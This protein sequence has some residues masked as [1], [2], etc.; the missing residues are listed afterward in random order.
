MF[1]TDAISEFMTM[2]RSMLDD[3]KEQVRADT[4]KYLKMYEQKHEELVQ[5]R[6]NL[7]AKTKEC[8]VKASQIEAM[9]LYI[10]KEK[11]KTRTVRHLAT[12]FAMMLRY[13]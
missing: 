6:E 5:T 12:P 11:N 13:K 1:K 8:E 10:A 7:L 9:T 4:E 2:K 3:Q